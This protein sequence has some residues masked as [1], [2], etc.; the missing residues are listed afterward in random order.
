MKI[1]TPKHRNII[2]LHAKM[3]SGAGTHKTARKDGPTA[4]EWDFDEKEPLPE[5]KW[6]EEQP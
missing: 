2:H 5:P 1:Q 3:K 4:E 6:K